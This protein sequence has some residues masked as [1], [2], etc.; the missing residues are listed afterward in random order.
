[1][2]GTEGAGS[3]MVAGR[4]PL[5]VVDDQPEAGLLQV[6]GHA[7]PHHA[8]PDESHHRF[9][10]RHLVTPFRFDPMPHN[11]ILNCCRPHESFRL[12]PHR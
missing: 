9:V 6:G 12:Y 5:Q 7:A 4:L 10:I 11:S 1:V 8:Q 2:I 3:E